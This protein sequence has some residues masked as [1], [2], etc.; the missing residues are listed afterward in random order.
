MT[1][2]TCLPALFSGLL[3]GALALLANSSSAYASQYD[4]LAKQTLRIGGEFPT[5]TFEKTA[6]DLK[7]VFEKYKPALD[8]DTT[9]ISPLRISGSQRRPSLSMTVEKCVLFVC[10]RVTLN[11]DISVSETAGSCERNLVMEIDLKRSTQD[12]TDVYD[13]I[14]VGICLNKNDLVLTSQARQAPSYDTGMIQQEIFKLLKKQ[15]TPIIQALDLTLK[16][17]AR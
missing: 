17:N 14:D 10:K 12:L 15:I 7:R 13:Q 16:E 3:L 11:A 1:A 2:K 5:Q 9:V 4:F 8:S 6:D